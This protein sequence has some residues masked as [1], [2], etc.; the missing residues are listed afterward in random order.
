MTEWDFYSS[1]LKGIIDGPVLGGIILRV[2]IINLCVMVVLERKTKIKP[3]TSFLHS[4]GRVINEEMIQ[5]QKDLKD[6]LQLLRDEID[7]NHK[8]MQDSDQK[9]NAKIE[10]FE[11]RNAENLKTV[12]EARMESDAENRRTQIVQFA[13]EIRRKD[14]FSEEHFNQILHTI[15]L[16][17]NYCEQHPNFINDRAVSSINVIKEKYEYYLKNNLFL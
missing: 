7:Q 4:I 9:L 11:L 15:T 2:V 5:E 3:F 12:E 14:K 16:Y 10:Q 1:V 13:D 6:Q 17:N 8:E